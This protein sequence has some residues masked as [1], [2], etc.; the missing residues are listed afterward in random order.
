MA[1][2]HLDLHPKILKA[3]AEAGYTEPTKIQEEAIPKVL[4]GADLRASSQ[5]GSG[6]TAAFLLPALNCL[7]TPSQSNGRG[8]RVLILAP[9]REL[10]MQISEQAE[11]YS[12]HLSHAKSVCVVGGVP[13]PIQ[14]RKLARRYDILIATPGR[15]I[16]FI[17]QGKIDF[18]RLEMLV[19]DEADRMLDMGFLE[20]VEEIVAE[21]PESRQ[22]L[23]F[24]ATLQGSVLKLSERLLKDPEE[25]IIHAEKERHENITQ[26]LHYVDDLGHKNRLLDHILD[27]EDVNHTIIFT[28][29]KRHADQLVDELY[30]KGHRVAALH[31]DMNQ[32]QRIRTIAR[33]KDGKIDIVVATD[34]AARGIDVPSISH[35]I[36]FD[37]PRNAEDY[38]HRIG[39]TGRAGAK[40]T[41]L[42]FAGGRDMELVKRIEKFTGQDFNVVEIAGLEPRRK[43][44]A[45]RP[46]GPRRHRSFRGPGGNGSNHFRKGPR[47][48]FRGAGGARR[49]RKANG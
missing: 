12:K 46:S 43:P 17:H 13:Y 36:N 35:V 4:A 9:T 44:Q 34:V 5:T 33:L 25:V 18:S 30:E 48:S 39:R 24:S 41:A 37:L 6:K 23:L 47:S 20:P 19:L 32:R 27:G 42:S 22:T 28:S 16:D 2:K 49:P 29:T 3:I 31:G 38:V 1:F 10:A 7:A 21:T 8:P 14:T 45:S 26:G 15:L 40:G 11:K